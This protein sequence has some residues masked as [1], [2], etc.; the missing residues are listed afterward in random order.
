ME[1]CR[2]SFTGA[3]EGFGQDAAFSRIQPVMF[4]LPL[5][6]NR[7]NKGISFKTQGAIEGRVNYKGPIDR[8]LLLAPLAEQTLKGSADL[9][10]AASGTLQQP[11][12]V[13]RASLLNGTYENVAQGIFLDK[14]NAQGQ[15]Q[16]SGDL[17]VLS[18]DVAASDGQ[19][20]A[21]PIKA[22]GVVQLGTKPRVDATLSLDRARIIHT[23]EMTLVA[24]G[25]LKLDGTLPAL[26]AAG[27]VNI[28]SFEFQI[29]DALPPDI[30]DIKVVAVDAHGNPIAPE[31]KEE[32]KVRAP[33]IEVALNVAIAGRQ[34][35][36]IR[37]RGLDS[38]WSASMH[39]SGTE[40]DPKLEGDLNLRRGSFDFAGRRFDL[41]QGQ[42]HFVPSRS[43]DPDLSLQATNQ[44]TSAT[45]GTTA[46][47]NISGRASKP[48]IKLTSD[49]AGLPADDVMALMLFGHPA[50]QLS[51]LQAVQL[52]NAV[53]TLS[54]QNPLSKGP[55][56]LDR[57][58][59]SLGL[60]LLDFSAGGQEGD[61][62][63]SRQ[64]HPPRRFRVRVAEHRHQD[65]FGF[66][67][68]R[69]F[70]LDQRTDERRAGIAR[71]RWRQLEARLL[72]ASSAPG[73]F[74]AMRGR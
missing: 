52:A 59:T 23:Q 44:T 7:T 37:G 45:T 38:E 2:V 42:I 71:E 46:I 66:G 53:A 70:A 39:V 34:Q 57:A 15:V 10:I 50:D 33:P 48:D 22:H 30:I 3:I 5:A 1:R 68:H 36:Y 35:I 31:E 13:G 21:S 56:I 63:D 69:P 49:P 20:A 43:T 41:S 40:S 60:D 4:S 16:H 51:A 12:F 19:G 28:Q 74:L 18:V 8:F 73:A 6:L 65:R 25:D 62:G 54:G 17:F 55:G 67:D 72:T 14:L 11:R 27:A 32:K 47:I 61:S 58:R 64:V 29:P 26:S 9:D 24:S